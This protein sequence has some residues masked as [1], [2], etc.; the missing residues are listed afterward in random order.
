MRIYTHRLQ[1]LLLLHILIVSNDSSPNN[2]HMI[3]P[4][5]PHHSHGI[6][7]PELEEQVP[8]SSSVWHQPDRPVTGGEEM[9]LLRGAI[10]LTL[11]VGPKFE[12]WYQFPFAPA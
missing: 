11:W 1:K 2:S 9:G 3:T 8:F 5:Q 10:F 7:V 4:I 6:R 12:D